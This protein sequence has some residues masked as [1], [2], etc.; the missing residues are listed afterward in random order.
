MADGLRLSPKGPEPKTGSSRGAPRVKSVLPPSPFRRRKC[1]LLRTLAPGLGAEYG[2][3]RFGARAHM[4]RNALPPASATPSG[5]TRAKLG[6]QSNSTRAGPHIAIFCNTR[7][8]PSLR[9][10]SRPCGARGFRRRWEENSTTLSALHMRG[11][12]GLPPCAHHLAVSGLLPLLLPPNSAGR[13][14][15]S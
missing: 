2:R 9:V 15:R 7:L 10:E 14:L 1:C 11:E 4:P 6:R 12:S 3:F 5:S 13:D 8:T